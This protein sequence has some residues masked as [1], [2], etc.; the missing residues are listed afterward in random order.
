VGGKAV[1][2]E[3]GEFSPPVHEHPPPRHK[4]IFKGYDRFSSDPA[5]NGISGIDPF[6]VVFPSVIGLTAEDHGYPGGVGRYGADHSVVFGFFIH[7]ENIIT[8][9]PE[10]IYHI[11]KA[12]EAVE[13]LSHSNAEA[14]YLSE[15]G[16]L[17]IKGFIEGNFEKI[18]ESVKGYSNW[19][20]SVTFVRNLPTE[21]NPHGIYG[22]DV[23]QLDR[24]LEALIGKEAILTPSGAGPAM[25]ILAKGKDAAERAQLEVVKMY[26]SQGHKAKG[27]LVSVR[28]TESKDD[29]VD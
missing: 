21:E 15:L 14:T 20:K 8:K 6:P 27:F 18:R 10:I 1:N 16:E 13:A 28:N 29:F 19:E 17:M 9:I 2:K 26:E 5:E 24:G 12:R 3:A 7:K 23:L 25:L 4:N 22:I 11:P